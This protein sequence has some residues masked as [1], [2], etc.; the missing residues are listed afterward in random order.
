MFKL[1]FIKFKLETRKMSIAKLKK[2][3]KDNYPY[4]RC[5][6][7]ICIQLARSL[8]GCRGKEMAVCRSKVSLQKVQECWDYKITLTKG[9]VKE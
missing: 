5:K 8:G 2:I 4:Q 1:V 6:V 9:M 3:D 7:E